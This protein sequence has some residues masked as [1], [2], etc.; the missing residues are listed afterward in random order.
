[1]AKYVPEKHKSTSVLLAVFLSFFTW[2]YTYKYDAWKFWIALIISATLWWLA[3]VPNIIIWIMAIVDQAGKNS[4][5][6][7]DYYK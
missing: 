3:F 7:K 1:M 6:Y 2:L 4:K 5:L